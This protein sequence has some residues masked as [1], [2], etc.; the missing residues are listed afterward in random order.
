MPSRSW[1]QAPMGPTTWPRKSWRLSCTSWSRRTA[2]GPSAEIRELP[3]CTRAPSASSS[4]RTCLARCATSLL[5]AASSRLACSSWASTSLMRRRFSFSASNKLADSASTSRMRSMTTFWSLDAAAAASSRSFFSCFASFVC[6]RVRPLILR[7]A[8]STPCSAS[9]RGVS[10]FC[11]CSSRTPRRPS[12]C[13]ATA[14]HSLQMRSYSAVLTLCCCSV[15]SSCRSFSSRHSTC[16]WSLSSSR[17]RSL[18]VFS[19]SRRF[20]QSRC[21]ASILTCLSVSSKARPSSYSFWATLTFSSSV[22][23]MRRALVRSSTL[24]AMRSCMAEM[25][26]AM[27][28]SSVARIKKSNLAREFPCRNAFESSCVRTH[29]GLSTS[30]CSASRISTSSRRV[31]PTVVPAALFSFHEAAPVARMRR[32]TTILSP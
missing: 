16:A 21:S 24:A 7:S 12:C 9:R 32:S 5:A 17:R 15:A 13:S 28:S 1:M 23:R 31:L 4:L 25:L 27:A 14:L 10:I 26:S 2:S 22:G 18:T 29:T 11:R 3:C 30:T 6:S 8:L 19:L 20:T